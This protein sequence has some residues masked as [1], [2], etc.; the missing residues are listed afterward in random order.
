MDKIIFTVLI[1]FFTFCILFGGC[2]NRTNDNDFVN[3]EYEVEKIEVNI[4]K[5][6]ILENLDSI[7]VK[8]IIKLEVDK[9]MPLGTIDKVIVTNDRVFVLDRTYSKFLFVYNR[10]G[11]LLWKIGYKGRG[12]GEYLNGPKD[13]VVDESNKSITVFESEI[14]ALF[15]YNW[16]G[17]LTNTKLLEKTWPY[18]FFKT[19]ST[20]YF[21]YKT[22]DKDSHLLRIQDANENTLFKYKRLDRKR[23]LV[24]DNSFF[25]T[26]KNTYFVEDYNNEVVV[27]K[28]NGI[29]KILDFDFGK[30]SIQKDFLTKYQGS[31]FIEKALANEKATNISQIVETEQLFAFQV[32]FKKA[33]F[34]IVYN[35]DDGNYLTGIVLNNGN[36]P[37]SVDASYD[38]FLVSSMTGGNI[39]AFLALKAS[40][41][42]VWDQVIES[43]APAIKKILLESEEGKANDYIFIY[44]L[45]M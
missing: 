33:K 18:S 15:T 9:K 45:H 11:E 40:S 6:I 36:L 43:A 42:K 21:A 30:N 41:P 25:S 31:E 4:D 3:S 16:E 34:Q 17:E 32:I 28:E 39:E 29:K 19:D 24:A 7:E 10:K 2:K 1:V 38:N 20:F 5:S 13:F 37:T 27:L 44:D 12:P 23:D 26:P 35:K 8:D 14:K 22:V